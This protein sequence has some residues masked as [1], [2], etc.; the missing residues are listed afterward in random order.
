MS[1]EEASR[2]PTLK[3]ELYHSEVSSADRV[4]RVTDADLQSLAPILS[5][6]SFDLVR[7]FLVVARSGSE[8]RAAEAMCL[9]QPAISQRISRLERLVGVPL[10]E[11]VRGGKLRLTAAGFSFYELAEDL[12]DRLKLA[13]LAMRAEMTG[14]R[15]TL[16]IATG[17]T[18][19]S[20]V[21]PYL[22]QA[23]ESSDE[24]AVSLRIASHWEIASLVER[25]EVDVG[26]TSE[27]VRNPRILA[28]PIFE[29][30]ILVVSSPK[31]PGSVQGGGDAL[32]CWPL[33]LPGP[34]TRTRRVVDEWALAHGIE[35]KVLVEATSHDV[36]KRFAMSG[37]GLAVTV[38]SAVRH[39]LQ[40]GTLASLSMPP[41]FPEI[42][43][44]Y[45]LVRRFRPLTRPLSLFLNIVE[46]GSWLQ[47]Y[48]GTQ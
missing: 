48:Q 41:D 2:D 14:E 7:T 22:L 31:H 28:R 32:G 16:V 26:I 1:R 39:E 8:R 6:L 21:L 30:R 12:I 20:Y 33:A 37:R 47:W 36:L 3:P 29:E 24:L 27:P 43:P 34:S 13:S 10:F 18:I 42:Q 17:P 45:V 25:G 11:R 44:L 15:S 38:Y 19:A 46:T 23:L 5:S 35:L 40:S 4:V 9:T